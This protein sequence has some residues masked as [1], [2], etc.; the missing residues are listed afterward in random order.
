MERPRTARTTTH[1]KIE[2]FSGSPNG[3]VPGTRLESETPYGLF[4]IREMRPNTGQRP[5]RSKTMQQSAE[6]LR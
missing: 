2:W 5:R 4:E 3:R 6:L 1:Q